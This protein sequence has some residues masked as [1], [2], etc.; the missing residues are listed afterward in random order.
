MVSKEWD[1]MY[2]Q[3]K[4]CVK[5]F[6]QKWTKKEPEPQFEQPC[7]RLLPSKLCILENE[8]K[9]LFVTTY[10]IPESGFAKREWKDDLLM[11]ASFLPCVLYSFTIYIF[12]F[13]F[14]VLSLLVFLLFSC[15]GFLP[16]FHLWLLSP[17]IMGW[18][19][20]I[21]PFYPWGFTNCFWFVVDIPS[22][23][24][25]DPLVAQPL[26]LLG[27]PRAFSFFLYPF[28]DKISLC[29]ILL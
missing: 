5:S 16:P 1:Y 2:L 24:P 27:K 22:G 8:P 26:P 25:A 3:L 13:L 15:R 10:G 29:L 28:H 12:F 7:H 17:F 23:L 4:S 21:S 9:W 18:F 6:R 20:K 14:L 11:H 19:Y